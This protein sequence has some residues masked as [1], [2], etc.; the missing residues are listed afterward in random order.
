VA[1]EHPQ[2]V[3]LGPP[4]P[5]NRQGIFLRRFQEL[6]YDGFCKA[7]AFQ[8]GDLILDEVFLCKGLGKIE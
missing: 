3:H 8:D 6:L 2:P 1:E 5:Q 4:V 7:T